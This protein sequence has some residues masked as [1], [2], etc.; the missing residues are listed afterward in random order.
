MPHLEQKL[1]LPATSPGEAVVAEMGPSPLSRLVSAGGH[2][3]I[4]DEPESAGG[5]D[6]GPGPYD[7]LAAA[8][9]ACVSMTIRL[10]AD[11]KGWPLESVEV[12]VVHTKEPADVKT[13][14]Q[15]VD[16]MVKYVKLVGNLTLEQYSRL[17]ELADK[18]PIH[19][20]LSSKIEMRTQAVR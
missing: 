11:R 9:G 17:L 2:I 1:H 3:F 10:V 19:R 7:L 20:T 4:A 15:P 5:A 18:C 16:H 8:L 6:T 13:E 14:R 12:R